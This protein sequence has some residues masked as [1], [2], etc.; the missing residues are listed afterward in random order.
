MGRRP[1][2]LEIVERF[3]SK[4]KAAQDWAGQY[5][6][7]HPDEHFSAVAISETECVLVPYPEFSS[8]IFRGQTHFFD[9][10][11]P[12]LFRGYPSGIQI[13][14][15]RIRL[16]EFEI[17][18][19]KHPAVIDFSEMTVA[20]CRFRINYEALAQHYGIKTALFD[21]TSNP[22][23]AAFFA[24]CEYDYDLN[25]YH[26]VKVDGPPGVLYSINTA[27]DIALRPERPNSLAI[28]LQPLRRPGEQY[29]WCYRLPGRV[30]LNQ[31]PLVRIHK[32]THNAKI[33]RRIF[34]MFDGG[35]KLFPFDLIAKKAYQ[36][37]ITNTFSHS[38]FSLAIAKYRGKKKEK[39]I[40]DEL[41]KKGIRIESAPSVSFSTREIEDM[42]SEWNK[43]R[44]DFI[45]R[46]H[47][48]MACS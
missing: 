19:S 41:L 21:F 4:Q 11:I 5:F 39:N 45:A 12:S 16:A 31:Q 6:E 37:S 34:E 18:L 46:I 33:S 24:C 7:T 48:R 13:F 9:P 22:F 47:Y 20:G 27:F 25:E 14:I 36:I 1:S 10:C 17:L 3:A 40:Y 35:K 38:A 44:E 8:V 23:V 32:F 26:P 2:V 42:S 29:A 30:S 15:E 43:R 28:G